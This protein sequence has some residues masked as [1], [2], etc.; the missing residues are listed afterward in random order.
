[1]TMSIGLIYR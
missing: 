1:M